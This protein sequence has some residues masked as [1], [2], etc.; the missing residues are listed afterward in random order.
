[1]LIVQI[2]GCVVINVYCPNGGKEKDSTLPF[3][4][5]FLRRLKNCIAWHQ[6]SGKSVVLVGDLNVVAKKIDIWYDL[7][8]FQVFVSH[9]MDLIVLKKA[10]F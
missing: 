5:E 7:Q 8:D 10:F 1:M 6:L 9:W 4:T 2:T 3:K